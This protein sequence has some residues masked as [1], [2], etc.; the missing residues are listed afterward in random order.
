MGEG[1]FVRE[2]LDDAKVTSCDLLRD[3]LCDNN[4]SFAAEFVLS[5]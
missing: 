4:A 2:K 3:T 5:F 1:L